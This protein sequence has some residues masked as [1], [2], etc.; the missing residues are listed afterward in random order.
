MRIL[1]SSAGRRVGLMKCF[2]QAA[3]DI[4][5]PLK[6]CAMDLEPEWSPACQYSD[7]AWNAPP[8]TEIEFQDWVQDLCQKHKI[9]LVVPT[10]D[11]ELPIY[12][13]IRKELKE[14]GTKIL[15]P[16]A[17][18]V[19]IAADKFRT[20]TVLAQHGISTP[21]S[22]RSNDLHDTSTVKLPV[23]AKP[24]NGSRSVG[25]QIIRTQLMLNTIKEKGDYIIQ[26]ECRG[27][28]Y[29]A[30]CYFDSN[31]GFICAVPH[32]RKK[33]RSGEVCYAETRDIPEFQT[34]AT[35]LSQIA[36]GLDGVL[37]VQGFKPPD[38]DLKI[39]EVNARFSGGYPLCDYA[40]GS[41]ARWILQRLAGQEPDYHND[42]RPGIRMLRYDE[43][44]YL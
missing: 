10:I 25:A 20:A 33:V 24:L 23:F 13:N 3:K 29:T 44:Y 16:A 4:G 15:L 42:W 40:G 35:K 22:R 14:R 28:E 38:E 2:R 37:S 36:P 21:R 5:V 30:N 9:D 31:R 32:Y 43:A 27:D 11:T 19:D 34:V 41:F 7:I 12:S 26:E 39:F 1:F 18:F 6:I 8:C 17:E